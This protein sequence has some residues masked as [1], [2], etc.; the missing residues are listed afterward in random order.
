MFCWGV[1]AHS[2]AL[3]SRAAPF[4]PCRWTSAVR[5]YA[6][7]DSISWNSRL[8]TC[9]GRRAAAVEPQKQLP[10]QSARGRL[11]GRLLGSARQGV[12]EPPQ[13]AF[14]VRGLPLL[15][16]HGEPAVRPARGHHPKPGDACLLH[17]RA[18]LDA[19][20]LRCGSSASSP[21]LSWLAWGLACS[22]KLG[23][24][25]AGNTSAGW[26]SHT[27]R[28][29]KSSLVKPSGWL[30][31]NA[32]AVEAPGFGVSLKRMSGKPECSASVSSK[33]SSDSAWLSCP[34]SSLFT[35]GDKSGMGEGGSMTGK[36]SVSGKASTPAM[37]SSPVGAA[38]TGCWASPPTSG[39]G[40]ETE[41]PAEGCPRN[42][43]GSTGLIEPVASIWVAG[44]YPRV[45]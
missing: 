13:R 22:A 16:E 11:G 39:S 7:T 29:C 6:T 19:I 34:A 36:S 37:A 8:S 27:G 33:E 15:C 2:S 28:L 20:S 1:I 5:A 40:C 10:D 24:D 21:R 26:I 45:A 4:P 12:E 17:R 25:G 32:L 14:L 30:S 18:A 44:R 31:G 41:P 35:K 9:P 38:I 43:T 3:G 42:G 23:M